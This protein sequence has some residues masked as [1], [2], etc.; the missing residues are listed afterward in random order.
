MRG[1]GQ[2]LRG[3]GREAADQLKP[4]IET[5]S[6]GTD[7]PKVEDCNI[8]E[9]FP[10]AYLG[11]CVPQDTF[12]AKPSLKRGKKFDWLYDTWVSSRKFHEVSQ[13]IELPALSQLAKIFAQNRQHDER[14]ALVCLLTAAGVLTGNYSAVGDAEGGY[15]FLP[16]WGC[17][18]NWARE[19]LNLQRGRIAGLEIWIDG[20]CFLSQDSLPT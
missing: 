11:V 16:P 20:E 13:R 17:W 5:E 9:A 2:R 3:A 7:F 10:N 1:T 14:A 15:F 12:L 4:I 6:C 8:V 18:A 19:E